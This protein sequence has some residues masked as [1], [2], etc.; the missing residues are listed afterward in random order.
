MR[1]S[2]RKTETLVL[3]LKGRLD[4]RVAGRDLEIALHHLI[5]MVRLR[6]TLNDDVRVTLKLGIQEIRYFSVVS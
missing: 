6:P 5:R 1:G 4:K 2:T 3:Y